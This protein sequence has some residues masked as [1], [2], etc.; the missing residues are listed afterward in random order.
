[1]AYELNTTD[2]YVYLNYSGTIDLE[3]RKRAKQEVLNLCYESNLNRSLVDLRNSNVQMSRTDVHNFAESFK[4]ETLPKNYRL[5]VLIS[6][7][8]QTEDLLNVLIR[9]EGVL[10]NYFFEYDEA[11][12]WLLA[13]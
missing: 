8:N 12:N 11:E 4:L 1:M 10:I 7:E 13:I 9:L 3:E 6:L 5:A 2:N